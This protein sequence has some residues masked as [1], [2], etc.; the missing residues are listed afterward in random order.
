MNTDNQEPD[1][2]DEY[3]FSKM[4]D[5]VR[6]KYHEAYQ[7]GHTVRIT[8]EDGTVEVHH[9]HWSKIELMANLLAFAP[10]STANPSL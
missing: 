5:A 3:D 8:R 6:G 10:Y 4:S 7:Q 1:M 9:Y 2:L